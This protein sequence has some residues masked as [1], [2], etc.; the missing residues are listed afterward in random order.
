MDD[1]GLPNK[2]A[3]SCPSFAGVMLTGCPEERLLPRTELDVMDPE[4][5]IEPFD[6]VRPTATVPS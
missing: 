3:A 1:A 4:V 6:A 2:E 5:G